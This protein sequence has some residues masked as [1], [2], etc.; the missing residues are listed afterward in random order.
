MTVQ[1]FDR[2]PILIDLYWSQGNFSSKCKENK[3]L[4]RK[5]NKHSRL[6]IWFQIVSNQFTSR[7]E[8]ETV[9]NMYIYIG[10]HRNEYIILMLHKYAAG[11]Q[12]VL[13][14]L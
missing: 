7:G 5:P 11:F 2:A 9:T 4:I 12:E 10:S 1:T 13:E 8:L 14:I 3:K 6:L